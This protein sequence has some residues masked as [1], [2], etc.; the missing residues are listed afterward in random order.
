MNENPTGT[1]VAILIIVGIVGA[2]VA[3]RLQHPRF[4][5][6]SIRKLSGREF[7]N[8][9]ANVGSTVI[10][11]GFTPQPTTPGLYV[12]HK[13]VKPNAGVAILLLLMCIVPG[14]LYLAFGSSDQTVTL[15]MVD[16]NSK[17]DLELRGPGILNAQ[18]KRILTPYMIEP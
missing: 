6:M 3:S 11:K 1:I 15:K 13:R 7:N 4:L 2:L 5:R 18:I 14:I 12:Y 10:S 16:A 9:M 17:Y 8:L